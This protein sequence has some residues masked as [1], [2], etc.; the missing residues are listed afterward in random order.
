MVSEQTDASEV[1]RRARRGTRADSYDDI[2]PW[3]DQLASLTPA[4][5]E[6]ERLRTHIF[7][8]CL[9]LAEHIA[10]RFAGRGQ[11]FEDLVQTARVGLVLAVDRFDN[12]R[13]SSFLGFAVPTIAG[14]VRRHFR[15][16]A[17]AAHVPR[18]MKELERR[19]GPATEALAQR[20]HRMPKA[21]ELAAEL[22]V[23]LTEL[24]SALVA[25]NAYRTDSLDTCAGGAGGESEAVAPPATDE[26]G[27]L[28]V[29]DALA[30]APLLRDMPER[31]RR[32]LILRFGQNLTQAEIARAIGVS[33]MHVSRMLTRTLQELRDRALGVCPSAV[34]Q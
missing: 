9:P 24:T 22:D 30:V 31:E 28:V 2:E 21:R 10:R 23:E 1:R 33:Q 8:L 15:D 14:E 27:Y 26:P 12:T 34:A 4:D 6:Y 13:G 19:I 20:L 7:E 5:P 11:E 18:R 17:W 3:F 25:A 16:H 32:M 29:D